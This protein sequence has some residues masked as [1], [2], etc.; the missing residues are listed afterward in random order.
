M[1]TNLINIKLL[2]D[3]SV[4]VVQNKWNGS[5]NKIG[6]SDLDK[7]SAFIV[8]ALAEIYPSSEIVTNIYLEKISD[9]AVATGIEI[10]PNS[11]EINTD[12][13]TKIVYFLLQSVLAE[14]KAAD[15]FDEFKLEDQSIEDKAQPVV[16]SFIE[17]QK[18]K[19]ISQPILIVLAKEKFLVAGKYRSIAKDVQYLDKTKV[20][21]KI[22]AI[23]IRKNKCEI[24]DD[25]KNII[26]AYFDFDSLFF[27]L[28]KSLGNNDN[29]LFE[30]QPVVNKNNKIDFL[31]SKISPYI[32]N[33]EFNFKGLGD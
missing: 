33:D 19:T 30:L 7:I 23:T 11:K 22:D 26:S 5:F 1:K 28:Y 16:L 15:L 20:S 32:R 18:G 31:L 6:W 13:L 12:L 4:N 8:I 2:N 10:I 3:L 29:H 27:E 9:V 21:G 24:M 17:K 14:I 25:K